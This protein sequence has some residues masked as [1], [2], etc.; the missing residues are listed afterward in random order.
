M[1][2]HFGK[3]GENTWN[4]RLSAELKSKDLKTADFELL[5]PTFRGIRKPDV[6]FQV[7][8]GIGIVSAKLCASKEVEAIASAQEYQQTIGKTQRIA[9]TFSLTYP[10]E[11][12]KIFH[13]R[14]LANESHG[15]AS[16]TFAD[17]GDVAGKIEDIATGK[18]DIARL[19]IENSVNAAIRVLGSGVTQFKNA[20]GRIPPK[21][22]EILFGGA[23]FFQS[24][25]GYDTTKENQESI[26]RSAAA[27]LFVNQILFYEILSR[28]TGDYPEISEEDVDKP[29]LIKPKYFDLVL[30]KD[31]IPI[32]N[33]DVAG[34]IRSRN[35]QDACKKIIL[36]IRALFPGRIEHDLIGK[37][38]HN[39]IPKDF[40]KVVGAYF[41]NNSAADLLALLSIGS[42]SDNVID[43][44]CGSG[45]LLVAAYKR[46]LE[47]S[48]GQSSGA[49]H[50]KYV[51]EEITGIDVMPFSA[52]LAAV[53]LALLAPAVETDNVR[54]AIEDSTKLRPGIII[55][56]AREVLKEAFKSRRLTDYLG[57]FHIEKRERADAG[58]VAISAKA[59]KP[60]RLEKVDVVLMNPPFTSC[61]NLPSDYK[62]ELRSRFAAPSACAKCLTGKISFQAYFLLLADRFL[63]NGGKMACVMPFMTLVGKAFEKLD[64]YVLQNYRVK[65][66]VYGIGRSAFSDNT[67][68]TELL[69]VAEKTKPSKKETFVLTATKK[70]PD[71]WNERDITE[72]VKQAHLT[73]KQGETKE[74]ELAI[75]KNYLQSDLRQDSLGLTIMIGLLDPKFS[76]VYSEI[77]AVYKESNVMADFKTL[78]QELDLDIF[79]GGAFAGSPIVGYSSISYFS[80]RERMK[81]KSDHFMVISDE[82]SKISVQDRFSK[83]TFTIQKK[84]LCFQVRRLTGQKTLDISTSGDYVVKKYFDDLEHVASSVYDLKTAQK[85]I[86]HFRAE[87]V[88]KINNSLSRIVFARRIDISAPGSSLLAVYSEEPAFVAANAWGIR[89]ASQEIAQF[90]TLWMNSGLFLFGLM[91]RRAPT[92]GA[93]GQ[94]DKR[95]LCSIKVPNF[96]RIS[97]K[98]KTKMISLFDELRTKE[99]PSIIDQIQSRNEL[100]RRID[101]TF[102]EVIGVEPA[103][104]TSIIERLYEVLTK[105]ILALKETMSKD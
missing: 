46:K 5:F 44:A 31:Y 60:L 38:F 73:E 71:E 62:A 92:R 14:V 29:N 87:A 54:I 6:A 23:D 39:L 17:I 16:W 32:F 21:E 65:Y 11:S 99:F 9:E 26:L 101:E 64:D 58:A 94:I 90:I 86:L 47:L 72:I 27:Y 55:E 7:Q 10:D 82:P 69:F 80:D 56:P 79:E 12:E 24:V 8:R 89:D 36:A 28:E 75:T 52:H 42:A 85:N 102:L 1:P 88:R 105:R 67:A 76:K 34:Q 40:R 84:F 45:T 66:I 97:P 3:V 95:Y 100:K 70:S 91:A 77:E 83:N 104:R 53:N 63:K 20:I 37:V 4:S 30:V 59:A 74:T 78:A 19:D 15:T 33:F 50:R 2:N 13:L 48:G 103:Q 61:D 35:A 51:E 43:L 81:K 49:L 41:T 68:L 25:V 96:A 93:W 57:D 22:F 18:W 98:H